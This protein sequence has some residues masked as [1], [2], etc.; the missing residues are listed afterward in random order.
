M[1]SKKNLK[2]KRSSCESV[3]KE[4]EKCM[5][6]NLQ[7]IL[8]HTF[9]LFL[10][11]QSVIPE[12]RDDLRTLEL[13]HFYMFDKIYVSNPLIVLVTSPSPLLLLATRL[14]FT[15]LLILHASYFLHQSFHKKKTRGQ[16]FK[17]FASFLFW[18]LPKTKTSS[19]LVWPKVP[20]A[21]TH[22]AFS[23]CYF[24]HSARFQTG[25]LTL[26][27]WKY[28][29]NTESELRISAKIYIVPCPSFVGFF[30][31]LNIGITAI[32]IRRAY[33]A[34]VDHWDSNSPKIFPSFSR[35]LQR[36]NFDPCDAILAFSVGWG[37]YSCIAFRH[38]YQLCVV[39]VLA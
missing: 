23:P 2:H 10:P 35:E 37:F 13:H 8:C 24:F 36:S 11:C 1:K 31:S 9:V 28:L 33:I 30:P 12:Y 32:D 16:P 3:W 6:N 7:Y 19:L 20:L 17:W 5:N 29:L 26:K 34:F 39:F 22:K 14:N 25:G 15:R 38:L 21:R 27:V 4:N 18:I